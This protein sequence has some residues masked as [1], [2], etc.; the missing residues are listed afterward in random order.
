MTYKI[1]DYNG[2]QI[3]GSVYEQ[4][5]QQKKQDIF[6]IEEIIKQQEN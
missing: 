2:E 4:E 1:T 5:L 6:R 3:Q